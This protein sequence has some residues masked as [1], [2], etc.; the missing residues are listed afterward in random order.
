MGRA[1]HGRWR[2]RNRPFSKAT[3]K[4]TVYKGSKLSEPL[5]FGGAAGPWA[6]GAF[7]LVMTTFSKL[8]T[9]RVVKGANPRRGGRRRQKP[10]VRGEID[11]KSTR[12]TRSA[13]LYHMHAYFNLELSSRRCSDAGHVR[14]PASGQRPSSGWLTL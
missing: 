2:L 5:V 12:D 10:P 3:E 9:A 6:T 4:N 14:N 11:R 1:K 8:E 13:R 7:R